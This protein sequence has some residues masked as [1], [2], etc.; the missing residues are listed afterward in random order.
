MSDAA[1]SKVPFQLQVGYD[2]DELLGARW[3]QDG[4]AEATTFQPRTRGASMDA[5]RRSALKVMLG[6]GGA[7]LAGGVVVASLA[8]RRA[9]RSQPVDQGIDQASLEL[10]RANGLDFGSNSATFAWTNATPTTFDDQPLDRSTLSQLATQLQPADSSWLPFYVPTLFQALTAKGNDSLLNTFQMVRSP[11][12]AT[13]WRRGEAVRELLEHAVQASKWALVIDLPGPESVAFAAALVPAVTPVF[14][15]ANWPH[16]RGVV[17]AHL[18]LGA[19]MH[20]R[21]RFVDAPA[22]RKPPAFVLARE[23]LAP[24]RNEPDR[25]DN[26]YVAKLPSARDLQTLGIERILYVVPE[27][28]AAVELDDLN[29]RFV[30]YRTAKIEVQMLGL[31]DLQLGTDKPKDA[32]N[33]GGTGSRYYWGGSLLHHWWFWNHF[34][35]PSQPGPVAPVRPPT[36]AFGGN[37]RPT[38][39][40]SAATG[41]ALLGRTTTGSGSSGGSWGRSS[42]GYGG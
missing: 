25:F 2:Q 39:R 28:A 17:P 7:V 32:A 20:F 18:T 14:V 13:A 29:A 37:Y 27:D 35:W 1:N 5:S 12:M 41:I 36:S 16:P 24:Y 10:Q 6:L 26:R 30:E 33:P 38:T 9:N 42:G 21:S 8:T 40:G 19:V 34:R 22:T 3:W 4:L 11:T 31:G 23:R 15:F